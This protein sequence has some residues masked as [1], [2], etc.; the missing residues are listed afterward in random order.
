MS[1]ALIVCVTLMIG[2]LFGVVYG[3]ITTSSKVND[4]SDFGIERVARLFTEVYESKIVSTD[5]QSVTVIHEDKEYKIAWSNITKAHLE[6][7][8]D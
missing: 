8:S 2:Q 1:K 7:E 4:P 6:F 5:E 3:Q